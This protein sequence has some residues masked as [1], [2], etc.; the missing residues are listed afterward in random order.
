MP[1]LLTSR[2]FACALL[3]AGSTF[4]GYA[5][6]ADGAASTP[7]SAASA[8]PQPEARP[9]YTRPLSLGQLRQIQQVGRTVL[10]AH[11]G[12]TADA[13]DPRQLDGMRKAVD[14]LIA[15]ESANAR[16]RNPAG[17]ATDAV[18]DKSQAAASLLAIERRADR[19]SDTRAAVAKARLNEARQGTHDWAARLEQ[20]AQLEEEEARS[21]A[22]TTAS[23]HDD[24]LQSVKANRARL[25]RQWSARLSDLSSDA[26]STPQSLRTPQATEI[27]IA[28]TDEAVRAA[29]RLRAAE[30]L[31]RELKASVR[32][33]PEQMRKPVETTRFKASRPGKF[34]AKKQAR[35]A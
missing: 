21:A 34:T 24:G 23:A 9:A 27:A 22:G 25:L 1:P 29:A 18:A 7:S 3:L 28:S 30:Q 32:E 33:W 2:L 31:R 12:E 35:K 5:Q 6:T 14:A 11:R 16:V 26:G 10:A 15:A 8:A 17:G 19:K 4:P 20:R 13:A